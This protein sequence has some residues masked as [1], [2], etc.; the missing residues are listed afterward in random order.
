MTIP[1]HSRIPAEPDDTARPLV[2][3]RTTGLLWLIN[4]TVFH[5][6][7]YALAVGEWS[8]GG[9]EVITEGWKLFGDGTQPWQ[10]ADDID[11][12]ELFRAA[13]AFLESLRPPR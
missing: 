7:G 5:P 12:D 4:R 2:D 13:E 8:V 10:F 1:A 6:R 9:S 11:E 3:L